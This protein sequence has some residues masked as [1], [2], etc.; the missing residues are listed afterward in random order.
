M[1]L[2]FHFHSGRFISKSSLKNRNLFDSVN[3][4]D[5]GLGDTVVYVWKIAVV[6]VP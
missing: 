4:A 6:G 3:D 1:K 5:F 2:I